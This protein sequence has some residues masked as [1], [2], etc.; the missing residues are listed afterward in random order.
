[1]RCLLGESPMLGRTSDGYAA[2]QKEL[3]SVEFFFFMVY[4]AAGQN[5]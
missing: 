2:E 3:F 5:N 4:W 1:M